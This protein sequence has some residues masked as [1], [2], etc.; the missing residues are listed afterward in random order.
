MGKGWP[1]TFRRAKAQDVTDHTCSE[2]IPE[3]VVWLKYKAK[4]RREGI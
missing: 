1:S 3:A 4:K 2:F